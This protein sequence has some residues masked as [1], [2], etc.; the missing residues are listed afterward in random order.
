MIIEEALAVSL[1]PHKVTYR[2][3]SRDFETDWTYHRSIMEEWQDG[4]RPD[5]VLHHGHGRLNVE[6]LVNHAVDDRKAKILKTRCE[7]CIEI[8]L[9]NYEFDRT[10]GEE[11]R[12]AIL[13]NAPRT[14]ISHQLENE[15]INI[16]KDEWD[17]QLKALGRDLLYRMAY[18]DRSERSHR[19]DGYESEIASLGTDAFVGR[20]TEYAHW[21]AI[22][23]RKWQHVVLEEY[24][25]R[26]VPNAGEERLIYSFPANSMGL[27]FILNPKIH[28]DED[29][30]VIK[31]AGLTPEQFGTPELAI[32]RYL[33]SLCSEPDIPGAHPVARR[34]VSFGSRP[35]LMR[36]NK[37][38]TG[39]LK[40]RFHLQLANEEAARRPKKTYLQWEEWYVRR[41]SFLGTT[42][43]KACADGGPRFSLLLAHL[44]A[45]TNMLNGGWPV[46]QLL[47]VEESWL[48]DKKRREY[49]RPYDQG[50]GCHP[51]YADVFKTC[52]SSKMMR[53]RQ[54]PDRILRAM[55]VRTHTS[56][57]EASRFLNTSHKLLGG[58]TPI[59]FATDIPTMQKCID[60]MPIDPDR[61]RIGRKVYKR[62]W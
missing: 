6:I 41:I 32:G 3:L 4:I 39:Y 19:D 45:I 35:G 55:A 15:R 51:Y 47:D 58:M 5:I 60:L 50:G 30:E 22:G 13:V 31:A 27:K 14:W 10:P 21:F 52:E 9:S 40:R 44:A 36:E 16:L 20:D 62:I 61:K 8:D 18:K 26:S 28:V 11:L 25:K 2:S 1:P 34:I 43:R 42:P 33:E 12:E 56:E 23:P 49:N 48:R 46:E 59:E 38:W 37:Q 53:S 7:S 29:P 57:V 24:L 54:P 17:V